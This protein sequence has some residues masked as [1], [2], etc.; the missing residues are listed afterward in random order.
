MSY[1]QKNANQVNDHN[2]NNGLHTIVNTGSFCNFTDNGRHENRAETGKS[3]NETP[4]QRIFLDK[5]S[6]KGNR[7]GIKP[8]HTEAK[9]HNSHKNQRCSGTEQQ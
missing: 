3:E 8:C 4:G 1:Q 9:A 5:A 6:G 2:C 7:S